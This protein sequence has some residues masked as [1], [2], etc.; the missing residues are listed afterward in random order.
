MR[1]KVIPEQLAVLHHESN[2]L[3]LANAGDR[4][5]SNGNEIS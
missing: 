2:S 3:Q 1:H 4:I 5:P